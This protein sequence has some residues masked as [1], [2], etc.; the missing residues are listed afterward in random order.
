MKILYVGPTLAGS[1]TMQRL[2]AM[3][4]LGHEVVELRSTDLALL[5]S[6]WQRVGLKLGLAVDLDGANA[7]LREGVGQGD[8]DLVWF[9]KPITIRRST[10]DWVRCRAPG[11]RLAAYSPDDMLIPPNRTRHFIRCL[12][13]FDVFFTTKPH[14][15][16]PLLKL[17]ARRVEL[18]ENAYAE[19]THKPWP[20]SAADRAALGG[21]IGFIGDYEEDRRRMIAALA[22]QG[23]GVR[24]WGPNWRRHWRHPPQDVR[25]E[26]RNLYGD[27]YARAICN[28]DIN[29][30]FLRKAARDE[31]TTRSLEIPACGG[32]MLAER[33]AAHQATFVE[34]REAEFFGSAAELAAKCRAYLAQPTRAAA[35]GAAG[36]VRCLRDGYGNR[37]RLGQ[38]LQCLDGLDVG[39]GQR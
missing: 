28:F 2:E 34:G 35:V 36:R 25:I 5:R 24:I 13:A 18:V 1:T 39:P 38:M 26:G 29:L 12:P 11:L 20:R 4:A 21:G 8:W 17:G 27:E 3:R 15:V 32:F 33:T 6:P 30:A 31:I 22:Q 9:D 7:A 16:A 37:A 14:N 23:L 10:L 19:E